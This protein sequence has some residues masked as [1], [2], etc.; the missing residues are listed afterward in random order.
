MTPPGLAASSTAIGG[1]KAA[2]GLSGFATTPGVYSFVLTAADTRLP[3]PSSAAGS[4]TI[5]VV[6]P[7]TLQL[8]PASGALPS[9][10]VNPTAYSASVACTGFLGAVSVLLTAGALPPGL[11]AA[12]VVNG[13]AATWS[14]SGSPSTAGFFS[15][16]LTATD[17]RLPAPAVAVANLTIAIN[18]PPAGIPAIGLAVTLLGGNL[19]DLRTGSASLLRAGLANLTGVPGA[20]V[21]ITSAQVDSVTALAPAFASIGSASINTTSTL[22]NAT[23]V[24][25]QQTAIYT[26]DP[27]NAG[28]A[29]ATSSRRRLAACVPV[30]LT[31][32]GPLTVPVS[33][34]QMAITLPATYYYAMGAVT[35]AQQAELL[36]VI[37]AAFLLQLGSQSTAQPALGGFVTSFA[38]CTGMPPSLGIVASLATLDIIFVSPVASSG[39]SAAE[40]AAWVAFAFLFAATVVITALSYLRNLRAEGRLTYRLLAVLNGV[41]ALAYLVLA[42]GSGVGTAGSTGNAYSWVLY[43][44]WALAGPLTVVL[45]GLLAGAHWTELLWASAAAVLG[46]AAGFAGVQSS[47]PNAA[48][49]LLSFAI[50]AGLLPLSLS[51]LCGFR[52]SAA[53][54]HT[55]VGRLYLALAT[56]SG[57][58][59]A[60]YAVVW[61]VSQGASAASFDQGVITFAVFDILT[62]VIFAAVL[63]SG[64]E[65]IARY[66]SW[67]GWVNTG[68]PLDFPIIMPGDR[69]GDAKR[70]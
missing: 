26:D 59:Y 45:L 55:E 39:I 35:P 65:A 31:G 7:P 32:S 29:V 5:E 30:D 16:Q 61:G 6:A 43:A 51:L 3:A 42:L 17:S 23:R 64:R 58:L 50:V 8:T 22:A 19:E 9:A 66:G 41:T 38:A 53:A 37:Q 48:W 67:L 62:K 20:S 28:N 44:A 40:I 57:L 4:Y 68:A 70:D 60:G 1:G 11:T 34:L 24:A 10:F 46:V 47:A 36:A 33:T 25:G 2:W 12:L 49:P 54:R 52:R 63:I 27:L 56:A 18:A 21:L 69:P 14:L 13:A 15:F